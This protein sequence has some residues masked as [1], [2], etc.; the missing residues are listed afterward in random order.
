MKP[1]L[2]IDLIKP[3]KL[4]RNSKDAVE[5]NYGSYLKNA[6]KGFLQLKDYK[7]CY[8][9]C[10]IGAVFSLAA[11]ADLEHMKCIKIIT[12]VICNVSNFLLEINNRLTIGS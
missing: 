5:V 2:A 1:T 3:M 9:I 12:S 10:K 6:A 8:E 11:A 4:V 7:S